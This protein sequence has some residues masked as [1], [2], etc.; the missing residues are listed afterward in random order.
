MNV[1]LKFCC[2]EASGSPSLNLMS[3]AITVVIGLPE[4]STASIIFSFSLHSSSLVPRIGLI[5]RE[6]RCYHWWRYFL[7]GSTFNP[8]F[9]FEGSHPQ[10]YDNSAIK[11]SSKKA[12]SMR[13]RKS[14]YLLN[15]MS[16]YIPVI[17]YF[18]VHLHHEY[19]ELAKALWTQIIKHLHIFTW[20]LTYS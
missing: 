6:F 8:I 18:N 20:T 9:I 15:D 16:L 11:V 7:N 13:C 1:K 19:R 3:E 5:C 12:N 4:P 10:N 14:N 17:F 2:Y